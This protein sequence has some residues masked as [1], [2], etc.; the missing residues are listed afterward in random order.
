LETFL[1]KY[2][3]R[4]E[5]DNNQIYDAIKRIE[6]KVVYMKILETPYNIFYIQSFKWW[7]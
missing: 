5:K 6:K 3:Y 1:V 2:E 7:K 4:K